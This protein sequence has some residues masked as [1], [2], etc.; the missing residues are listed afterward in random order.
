VVTHHPF[1]PSPVRERGAVVGRAEEAM[2]ALDASRV[3][4]ILSGHL[5]VSEAAATHAFYR[6]EN[7]SALMIQAG[8][9]TSN[10][11]R[12]EKNSYNTITID[13]GVVTIVVR[14]WN[15]SSFAS[16]PPQEYSRVAGLWSLRT[17]AR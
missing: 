7:H 8:T 11:T 12:T 13:G 3:D 2:R 4:L 10:R 1:L 9:A 5:H 14:R 17:S 15:G 6:I 16:E